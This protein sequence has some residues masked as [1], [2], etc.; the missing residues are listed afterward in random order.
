MGNRRALKFKIGSLTIN[1]HNFQ[2]HLSIL[3][4]IL[5]SGTLKIFSTLHSYATVVYG[6]QLFPK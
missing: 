2:L 4:Q 6:K 3:E 1:G 5:F